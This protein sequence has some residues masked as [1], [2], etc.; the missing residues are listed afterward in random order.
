MRLFFE[1]IAEKKRS[2][3]LNSIDWL[4]EDLTN[5]LLNTTAGIEVVKKDE[6]NV[7]LKGCLSGDFLAVCDRCGIQVDSRIN[8]EF[9]YVVTTRQETTCSAGEVECTDE[10]AKTLFLDPP[11]FILDLQDVFVEQAYLAL[12]VRT[13]C[14]EGCKGICSGCGVALNHQKCICTV[15]HDGSPFAVLKNLNKN[16]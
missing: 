3:S 5:I 13:L 14:N 11:D 7:A 12:P 16:L 15:D 1:K 8:V 9:D 2:F 4:P 6:G 10:D